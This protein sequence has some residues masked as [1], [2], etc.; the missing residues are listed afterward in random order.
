MEVLLTG[1]NDFDNG[2]SEGRFGVELLYMRH[3][4]DTLHVSPE[5]RIKHC[6]LNTVESNERLQPRCRCAATLGE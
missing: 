5:A 6:I 4:I 2:V 3:I 1:S